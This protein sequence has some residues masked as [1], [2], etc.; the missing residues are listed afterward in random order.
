MLLKNGV[1]TDKYN[2]DRVLLVT[3]SVSSSIS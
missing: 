1:V 3:L 2:F